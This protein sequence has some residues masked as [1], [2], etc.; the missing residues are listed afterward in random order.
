MSMLSQDAARRIAD[1]L[2]AA[3][4][5]KALDRYLPYADEPTPP[6][7]PGLWRLTTPS[8]RVFIA[9][10][11]MQCVALERRT[12]IPPQV[13]LGRIAR[14]LHEVDD[15]RDEGDHDLGL[16]GRPNSERG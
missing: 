3:S 6:P 5:P 10:G 11:P 4:R 15:E 12:R 14:T 9:N 1:Q 16:D 2:A 8:G 7:E 13:A